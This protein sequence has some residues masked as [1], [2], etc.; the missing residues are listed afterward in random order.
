MLDLYTRWMV[1]WSMKDRPTQELVDEALKMAVEQRRPEP[2]FLHHSDQGI[3]YAS[4]SYLELMKQHGM[5]R[6]MSGR[7]N[8]YDNAVVESFFSSLKN[9]SF[10]IEITTEEMKLDRKFLSTSNCS[11]TG[12][13]IHQS[14]N[15]QTPMQYES[16]KLSTN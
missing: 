13:R 5:V 6:S 7:G 2:G 4:G 14:L 11:T 12:K 16:V 15:Y 8:C 3:Q 10:T 9:E 1:G